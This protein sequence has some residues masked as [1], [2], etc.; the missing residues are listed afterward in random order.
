[1]GVARRGRQEKPGRR[2]HEARELP[3]PGGMPPPIL[4]E[5]EELWPYQRGRA[6]ERDLEG[7]MFDA[8]VALLLVDP[9]EPERYLPTLRGVRVPGAAKTGA[10]FVEVLRWWRRPQV[11]PPWR[12]AVFLPA[13]LLARVVLVDM[14]TGAERTRRARELLQFCGWVVRNV[15]PPARR[16]G[17]P[18]R[19]TLREARE[20]VE[21][22]LRSH[23]PDADVYFWSAAAGHLDGLEYPAAD[24]TVTLPDEKL[25]VSLRHQQQ[26]L[27]TANQFRHIEENRP[28]REAPARDDR[29]KTKSAASPPTL[30]R[31]AAPRHRTRSPNSK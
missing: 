12:P 10:G 23:P 13:A 5:P 16:G 6:V 28:R 4:G 3:P 29:H 31:P 26:R 20:K 17:R 11:W 25:R 19:N 9:R 14:A 21:A 27:R 1:M 7:A 30:P 18:R 22:Y 8:A 2:A 15:P 24:R